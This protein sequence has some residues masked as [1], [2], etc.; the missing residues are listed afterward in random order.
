MLVLG[1]DITTT[2]TGLYVDQLQLCHTGDQAPILL[3]GCTL[4][5]GKLQIH[6]RGQ[7]HT[8]GHLTVITLTV[9]RIRFLPFIEGLY[10]VS[11]ITLTIRGSYRFIEVDV[12]GEGTHAVHHAVDTEVVAMFHVD[13]SSDNTVHLI[14]RHLTHTVHGVVGLIGHARHTV[15]STLHHQSA[16]ED[17]AE[18]STLNGIHQTTCIDRAEAPQLPI[19]TILI[20]IVQGVVGFLG[21]TI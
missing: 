10:T 15:L 4:L 17:T 14:Q 13:I 1:I 16:T 3:L 20:L 21:N 11:R 12:A 18:V 5:G 19:G 9:F 8:V 2:E 6:T 7:G